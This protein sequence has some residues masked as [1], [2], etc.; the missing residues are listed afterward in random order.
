MSDL[1]A[2]TTKLLRAKAVEKAGDTVTTE[3]VAEAGASLHEVRTALDEAL[4]KAGRTGRVLKKRFGPVERLSDANDDLLLCIEA[5]A[6]AR[7][8]ANFRPED[9]DGD[10]QPSVQTSSNFLNWCHGVWREKRRALTGLLKS[11][12][13]LTPGPSD[14]ADTIRRAV[15]HGRKCRLLS[16]DM[17]NSL[18]ALRTRFPSGSSSST[19]S[20]EVDLD[21]FLT[22]I[23]ELATWPSDDIDIR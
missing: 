16:A 9:L 5:V 8:T 3:E 18:T 22:N 1:R 11:R 7:A 6:E 19:L 15:E 4:D 13:C 20:F 14:A 12:A 10:L 23:F 17:A 2:F 21:D